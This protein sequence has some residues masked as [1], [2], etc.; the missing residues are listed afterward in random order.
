MPPLGDI[1]ENIA[2]ID[3]EHSTKAGMSESAEEHFKVADLLMQSGAVR[4]AIP[5]FEKA[6]AANP[7][8][9]EAHACYAGALLS[10]N[11]ENGDS[12]TLAGVVKHVNIAL[13]LNPSHVNAMVCAAHAAYR[14]G[15]EDGAII[16]C[17][18]A[19]MADASKVGPLLL[20]GHIRKQ[21]GEL[22]KALQQYVS[23]LNL[24]PLNLEAHVQ[25]ADIFLLQIIMTKEPSWLDK[26]E[27]HVVAA[28][29]ISNSDAELM[30][31]AGTFY[32][33][34]H[35]YERAVEYCQC[36]VDAK[37][38][39]AAARV[40]LA[41]AL[42]GVGRAEE[43][44]E[45]IIK[46][47][48][49][50]E[51]DVVAWSMLAMGLEKSHRLDEMESAIV[52]LSKLIGEEDN[53]VQVL[54]GSL[55]LR[56]K[57]YEQVITILRDVLANPEGLTEEQIALAY[58]DM[59][60]SFEKLERFDEAF[61]AANNAQKY[62][63]RSMGNSLQNSDVFRETNVIL[64]NWFTADSVRDW[65][66]D[67][68]DD[69]IIAPIFL[70][71]FPRSGTTLLEQ[72]LSSHPHM[73]GTNE[74]NLL[75]VT[76]A[77]ISSLLGDKVLYPSVLSELSSE[78]IAALRQVYAARV[79]EVHGEDITQKRI[80]DKHPLNITMLGMIRRIFPEARIVMMLRDPRDVVLSCFFQVFQLN[81]ATVNFTSLDSTVELYGDILDSWQHYKSSLGLSYYE[82]KYEDLVADNQTS[83]E[84]LMEFV[85]EPWDAE[86]LSYHKKDN[87]RMVMTPSYLGVA[88]PLYS[89]SV[90]KWK[91]Y[92]NALQPCLPKLKPYIQALGYGVEND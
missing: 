19:A 17:N 25:L 8:L 50:D 62:M 38:Q 23:I 81:E 7:Y 56:R 60:R 89:T 34:K 86:M 64:R 73:F 57:D 21:R 74:Y 79:K 65:P 69:G 77:H 76:I 32:L 37:P 66:T 31:V 67:P 15:D 27:P 11:S 16:W 46:A 49:L 2:S 83:L 20:L 33:I 3:F 72:M 48:E 41:K 85:G 91:R 45:H 90:A 71:G 58:G 43:A 82:I 29:N 5:H 40:S 78:H 68:C 75:D 44:L 51:A 1:K 70:I 63:K 10:L 80:V 39:D 92:Q 24:D 35:Q 22:N 12:E 55:A 52:R 53:R 36:Y 47:T 84:K 28:L 14:S 18:K 87:R 30:R 88:R 59:F 13:E 26:A 61:V 4:E 54:R 9:A 42:T 6:I